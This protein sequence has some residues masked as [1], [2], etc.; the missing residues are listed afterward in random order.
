MWVERKK[1][2]DNS[3][4]SNEMSR[5][6]TRWGKKIKRNYCEFEWIRKLSLSFQEVRQPFQADISYVSLSR[7]IFHS[8]VRLESLTYSRLIFLSCQ[9][10]RQPDIEFRKFEDDSFLPSGT[11]GRF[12][13]T[14]R[15]IP[16]IVRTKTGETLI[17][18]LEMAETP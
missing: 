13:I 15:F 18:K 9:T 5:E 1:Q 2:R 16:P 8:A 3:D 17:K 11:T 4:D 14:G 7:L 6:K 12:R 10:R